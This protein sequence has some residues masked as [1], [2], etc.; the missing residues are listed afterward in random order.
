MV[1]K[2]NQLEKEEKEKNKTR[3]EKLAGFFYNVAQ[4]SFAGLVIGGLVPVFKGEHDNV[5]WIPV[6]LGFI[7]TFI[8]AFYANK[9]LK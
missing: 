7:L 6:L 1:T 4:L 2:K 9:I 8:S 5:N 3:K